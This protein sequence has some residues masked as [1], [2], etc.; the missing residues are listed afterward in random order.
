M[1]TQQLALLIANLAGTFVFALSGALAATRRQLDLFGVLVLAFAAANSGGIARDVLIGAVPPV[2]ISD[3]RYLAAAVAA[4]IITFRWSHLIERMQHPVR[5][6]DA[7]GLALFTV[8]GAHKALVFGLHPVMAA[9]LGMLTG[10]GGGIARDLLLADVPMVLRADLYAVAALVGATVL[11]LGALLGLPTVATMSAGAAA[12]FTLRM[13]AVK[14]GWHLPIAGRRGA[15]AGD[16]PPR[17]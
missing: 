11:V 7:A 17:R 6:F 16:N 8:T 1:Q 5:M 3:W 14:R 4:G 15:A 10:I 9:L 12:C 2:A 13:L